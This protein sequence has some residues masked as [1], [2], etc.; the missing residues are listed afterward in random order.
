LLYFDNAATSWPKPEVVYE[1]HDRALRQ[2]GNAGRGVNQSSLRAGRLLFETREAICRLFGIPYSER[3]VFTQNV[4]EALNVGLQG[5]LQPGDHVLISS[6][7]HNA[8]IR[9]LEY[10]QERGVSYTVVPCSPEGTLDA[11]DVESYIQPNTKLLCFTHASNVL[12][13][14]LP[15]SELGQVAKRHQCWFMVDAAQTGGVLPIHVEEQQI[16][17]L[18]FT[19]HKGLMGPQGVGGFYAKPG[20]ELRSLIYGGTGVHSLELKQ[21]GIWPEGMESGTRNIPGIAALEAGI[22]FILDEGLEKIRNHEVKLMTTLLAGL[23]RLPEVQILGPQDP[24]RRVGLVSCIFA[25][26]S[27]E[28]VS[29]ELDRRYDIVSREG[30]HCAPLAHK[31]AG[32]LET[33]ALRFSLSYFHTEADIQALLD[34]L[35]SVIGR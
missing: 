14:I 20:I 13:S 19:G 15:I 28:A 6:V 25:H 1:T 32:T 3:V 8:V 30:L 27:P 12:G 35:A 17:F 7:E 16:D 5:L 29:L 4:T 21:P 2:G 10:L 9:P 18:A 34:A 33:G 22:E 26:H 31:T 11:A 23:R 24:G